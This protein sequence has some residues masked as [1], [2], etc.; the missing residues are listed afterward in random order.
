M[1]EFECSRGLTESVLA[2]KTGLSTLETR[3]GG[4]VK[5]ERG[6]WGCCDNSRKQTKPQ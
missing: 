6:W 2:I 3:G 1:S 5:N 4:L